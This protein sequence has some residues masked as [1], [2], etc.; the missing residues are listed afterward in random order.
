M[1]RVRSGAAAGMAK[2]LHELGA[3]PIALIEGVGLSEAQF[4]DPD[5]YIPY[6]KL[7]EMMELGASRC[8]APLFGLLLAE[9]Q[10]ATVL[11]GLALAVTGATT[12]GE[13]L[14]AA[15]KYLYLH[16]SGVHLEQRTRDQRIHLSLS[17]DVVSELGTDQLIQM[18]VGHLAT[19]TADLL[20]CDRFG[21]PLYF[22]QAPPA[23]ADAGP[24]SRFRQLRF[25]QAFDGI[26]IRDKLLKRPMHRD[27]ELLRAH[28]QDYLQQLQG[29]YPDSLE[30][31]VREIIGHLLPAGEC[32]IERVAATLDM[33]PR[34]LQIRLSQQNR[35]YRQ[36][37]QATRF[38]LAQRH[39]RQGTA[40]ITDLALQLGYAEVAVFSRHFKRWSGMSP[41]EW[42]RSQRAACS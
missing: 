15:A 19:F 12:V 27:T 11:G 8:G 21:L 28:F 13:A 41:R 16:A 4:R 6:S 22:R 17:L 38:D 14:E 24:G 29:R 26:A 31:Q 42:Q 1:Y 37:L 39:L 9:R 5:T 20:D 36:I 33:H 40:S 30:E 32:S 18:S 23:G 3:N 34:T 25:G 7:A 10:T 2:L 35:S